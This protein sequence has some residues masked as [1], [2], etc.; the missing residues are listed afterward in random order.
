MPTH[1]PNVN[2]IETKLESEFYAANALYLQNKMQI[3]Y[4]KTM[5]MT[6]GTRKNAGDSNTLT[7]QRL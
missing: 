3:S 4:D 6:I 2:V 7:L 5:C 1:S